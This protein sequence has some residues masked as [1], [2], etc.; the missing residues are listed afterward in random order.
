MVPSLQPQSY[1]DF[2]F[3]DNNAG[4]AGAAAPVDRLERGAES[5]HACTL[6][7]ANANAW[8]FGVWRTNANVTKSVQCCACFAPLS[9]NL[10][11]KTK[12]KTT[13]TTVNHHHVAHLCR[14][15]WHRRSLA[16]I[17]SRSPPLFP[18]LFGL[19]CA[20]SLCTAG[21]R[22]AR[23]GHRGADQVLRAKRR[24]VLPRPLAFRRGQL[25][26]G[27]RL[28]LAPVRQ[29]HS[30]RGPHRAVPA[31]RD[32]SMLHPVAVWFKVRA[33]TAPGPTAWP[34]RPRPPHAPRTHAMSYPP[35]CGC[36]AH[37]LGFA[38]CPP[39]SWNHVQALSGPGPVQDPVHRPHGRPGSRRCTWCSPATSTW[40]TPCS[41]LPRST[42]TSV[43]ADTST[44]RSPLRGYVETGST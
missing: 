6:G 14:C 16:L 4:V 10:A 44:Q 11:K 18:S 17:L 33:P 37:I 23:D 38:R 1:H 42:H 41:R 12:K 31:G 13:T 29:R 7:A 21:V 9:V 27:D 39:S 19:T 34:T 15:P 25:L 26:G 8:Y 20:P 43:R 22:R 28:D 2:I 3:I 5:V 36:P 30:P 35:T 32:R 24:P 40:G